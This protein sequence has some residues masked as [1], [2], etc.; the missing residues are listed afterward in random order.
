M[1]TS[2]GVPR[3]A[4]GKRGRILDKGSRISSTLDLQMVVPAPFARIVPDPLEASST[5][6]FHVFPAI[7]SLKCLL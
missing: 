6:S 4:V 5:F 2:T 1:Y 3:G 7:S